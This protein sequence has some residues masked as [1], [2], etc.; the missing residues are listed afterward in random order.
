MKRGPT[1]GKIPGETVDE[2][3]GAAGAIAHEQGPQAV[4]IAS[5]AKEAGVYYTAVQHHFGAT[6]GLLAAVAAKG[7]DELGQRL[8]SAR[9]NGGSPL[10]RSWRA[11][12][13]HA[14]FGLEDPARYHALH[15]RRLWEFARLPATKSK[16]RDLVEIAIAERGLAFDEYVAAVEEDQK[17]GR[18][19]QSRS[20]DAIA[21]FLSML[22]DGYLFQVT[23]EQ[24][25][26]Q[27]PKQEQLEYLG[28]ML[29]LATQ[30]LG[31]T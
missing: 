30:G 12:L 20:A 22:V 16:E 1:K 13:A 3:L 25:N 10:P 14:E 2:I 26:A 11:C 4:N 9:T 8:A 17:S 18:I 31:R 15:D 27:L 23:D 24:V 21:H 28:Q 6:E 19:T 7:F 5:V 29:E